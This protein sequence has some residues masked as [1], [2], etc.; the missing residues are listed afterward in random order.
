MRLKQAKEAPNAIVWGEFNRSALVRLPIVH[1]DA[2][3]RVIGTP[4]IE[5]R[6]PDGS[7]LPHLLLAGAAIASLHGRA[8][9]DLDALLEQTA[10]T[11]DGDSDGIRRRVP[12]N[13]EEVADALAG[14]RETLER[15]GVFPSGLI[16]RVE[17]RLKG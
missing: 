14:F 8:T 4:T 15:G 7:A 6:L 11:Y 12:R 5:F 17:K 9:D 1:Q 16:E 2:S 10:A 13:P 3:G